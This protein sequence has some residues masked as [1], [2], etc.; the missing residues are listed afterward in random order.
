M[1]TIR[2]LVLVGA[3]GCGVAGAEEDE[4]SKY[5]RESIA[6]RAQADALKKQTEALE[7]IARLQAEQLE[8]QKKAAKRADYRARELLEQ[9]KLNGAKE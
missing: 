5:L 4:Y 3:L 9:E 8:E 6:A 7:R 1:K 2:L